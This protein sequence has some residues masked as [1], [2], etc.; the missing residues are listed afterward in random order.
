MKKAL[1]RNPNEYFV[2]L[3]MAATHGEVGQEES[4]AEAA[5]VLRIDP[6]FSLDNYARTLPVCLEICLTE[7]NSS[8]D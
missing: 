7:P 8:E 3:P 1:H 5:E 6:K 2:K 4:R